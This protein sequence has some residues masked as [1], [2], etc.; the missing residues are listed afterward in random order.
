MYRVEELLFC[1]SSTPDYT[2]DH[3]TV[4]EQQLIQENKEYI[5]GLYDL[6]KNDE[7]VEKMLVQ[8]GLS[9]GQI[10]LILAETN[11]ERKGKRLRQAKRFLILSLSVAIILWTFFIIAKKLPGADTFGSGSNSTEDFLYQYFLIY[12]E[13]FYILLTIVSIQ[14]IMAVI[15]LV[16]RKSD[17]VKFIKASKR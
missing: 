2:M 3:N 9:Y 14:T 15:L 11:R 5:L 17:W 8:K 10:K 4:A 13:A 12:R 6:Y 7:A 16:K 1:K